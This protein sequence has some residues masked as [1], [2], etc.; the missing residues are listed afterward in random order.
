MMADDTGALDPDRPTMIGR[1]IAHQGRAMEAL[2]ADDTG[3][4]TGRV[5]GEQTRSSGDGVRT[6]P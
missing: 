3:R 6:I 2:N 5:I 4:P 1:I